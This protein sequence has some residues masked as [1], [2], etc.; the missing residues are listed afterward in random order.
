VIRLVRRV[1][2][3]DEVRWDPAGG[4]IERAGL[5]GVDGVVHLAGESIASGPWTSARKRRIRDSRVE[6]TRLLA[7]AL[8]RLERR[9]AV[10]V[11]ASAVGIY[12][13]RGDEVLEESA[14]PG[15]GFLAEVGQAWEAAT[16]PARE[17]GIRVVLPRLGIVLSPSGGALAR[18][19][20]LFRLGLGGRLGRGT[21]WMSWITLDDVVRVLIAALERPDLSGPLNT[22]A[23]GPVTNA[24]FTRQLA[25]AVRRPAC[26]DAPAPILELLLGEMAREVLLASQRVVPRALLDAGFDFGDPML[27]PAL[28]RIVRHKA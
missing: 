28:G 13:H 6:G 26:L 18:L 19:I 22:V 12:G 20:P 23:P 14:A 2:G 9:P 15:T 21:Q 11:S 16:I 3:P 25:A 10:L 5:E 8:V 17:S 4:S 7:D 27:G 24:D 1:P